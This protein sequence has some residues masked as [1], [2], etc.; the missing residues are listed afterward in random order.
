MSFSILSFLKQATL[1]LSQSQRMVGM[2][3]RI[4]ACEAAFESLLQLSLQL[5][6]IFLRSDTLP[7]ALQVDKS[8]LK[9]L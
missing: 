1:L 4:T 2:N 8:T 5:Y 6:I 7:S 3:I 9:D